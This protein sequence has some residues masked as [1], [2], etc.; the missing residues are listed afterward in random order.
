MP[1]SCNNSA[2]PNAPIAVCTVLAAGITT[3][4]RSD[5][6]GS[7]AL[8]QQR[9]G[10]HVAGLAKALL[11]ERRVDQLLRFLPVGR[12]HRRRPTGAAGGRGVARRGCR[13][14]GAR[15]RVSVPGPRAPPSRARGRARAR[16]VGGGSDSI[17]HI[18]PGAA[19][20]SLTARCARPGRAERRYGL[21]P[22]RPSP[23]TAARRGAC[24]SPSARGRRFPRDPC[25]P[26][27]SL[28]ALH[29]LNRKFLC[30]WAFLCMAAFPA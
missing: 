12:D 21:M 25:E 24:A 9:V 4:R 18:V 5:A 16:A 13:V 19:G 6:L 15:V 3:T 28:C 7:T 26:C 17:L 29:R 8:G 10:G 20:R 23:P 22:A 1:V 2:K 30:P 14:L 27:G 11:G